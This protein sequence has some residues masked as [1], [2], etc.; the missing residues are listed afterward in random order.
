M[1]CEGLHRSAGVSRAKAWIIGSVETWMYIVLA[2]NSLDILSMGNERDTRPDWQ[3]I[4]VLHYKDIHMTIRYGSASYSN[5]KCTVLHTL[6]KGITHSGYKALH[7]NVLVW[8]MG[9][10]NIRYECKRVT[11]AIRGRWSKQNQKHTKPLSVLYH[12]YNVTGKL[13]QRTVTCVSFDH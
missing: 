5:K 2:C 13:F 3:I 4:I 1:F 8:S 6:Y 9:P 7:R 12:E 11:G 10:G